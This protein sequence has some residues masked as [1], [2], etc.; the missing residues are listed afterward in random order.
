[1]KAEIGTWIINFIRGL[2]IL[3]FPVYQNMNKV[4]ICPLISIHGYRIVPLARP[5][6]ISFY[7]LPYITSNHTDVS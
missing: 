3:D 5:N 1:M 7:D 4:K 6:P 2:T